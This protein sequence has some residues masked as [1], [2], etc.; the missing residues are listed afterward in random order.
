M[1]RRRHG[2]KG[3]RRRR[4]GEAGELGLGRGGASKHEGLA[5]S[6]GGWE[7]GFI[8]GWP[9][10]EDANSRNLHR[11]RGLT[12]FHLLSACISFR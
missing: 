9:G 5:M 7:E 8:S 11:I 1:P 4:E 3:G 6:G 10:E 2:K 12:M